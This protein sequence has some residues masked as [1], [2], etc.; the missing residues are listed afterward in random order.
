[1]TFR[2]LVT[3]YAWPSL[4]PEREILAAAGCEILVAPEGDEQQLI[5]LAPEADA[6]LTNWRPVTGAVLRDATRCKVVARYGVG[7]DNIDI[8]TASQLGIAVCN[9]PDFCTEEVAD[10]AMALLLG[11]WRRVAQFAQ[12][13]RDG[14]WD[15]QAFGPMHRLRGRTL[16]LV[17]YGATAQAVASRAQAFGLSV[18]AFAPSRVGSEPE[19]GVEFARSLTELLE[20][21]QAVSLHLPAT[22]HT[23]HLI[24]RETLRVLPEGAILV[25]TARGALIDESALLEALTDGR[26]AGAAL[27]VTDPEPP[28]P[29]SPLRTHPRVL[30]TPHAAF[31]SVES[32]DELQRKAATNVVTALRGELPST[33]LNGAEMP[34][35]AIRINAS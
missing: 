16:G 5:D 23:R 17:G 7:V 30:L 1:M 13:T 33:T 9:V 22:E 2:V 29:A 14:G 27:D 3:D 4:D 10:H 35:D 12:Q 11:L 6:V 19:E 26:L 8:A 18:A 25:N 32:I 31:C 34:T 20:K 28:S 21:S 15:I 24:N